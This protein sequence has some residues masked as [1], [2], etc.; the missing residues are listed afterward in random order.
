MSE[1]ALATCLLLAAWLASVA[2][3]GWLAGSMPVHAQ[4]VWGRT[5]SSAMARLL[6][7]LGAASIVAALALCLGA[8]HASMAVLVW[9]MASTGAALLVA[10]TLAWR[11][12]WLRVLAPWV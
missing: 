7:W 12:R 4:Q 5:P 11:P 8:D 10:F 9:V 2:G 6:R 1:A 3:M